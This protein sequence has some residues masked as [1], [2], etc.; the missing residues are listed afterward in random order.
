MEA[1]KVSI[2]VSFNSRPLAFTFVKL[3]TSFL[4]DL[5]V[6]PPGADFASNP[7]GHN[8]S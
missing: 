7:S 1:R 3:T 8:C 4:F 6:A 2:V 5:L